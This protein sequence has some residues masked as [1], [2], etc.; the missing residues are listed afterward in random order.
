MC[1]MKEKRH[2]LYKNVTEIINK[3]KKLRFAIDKSYEK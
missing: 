3:I 2:G 1:Q